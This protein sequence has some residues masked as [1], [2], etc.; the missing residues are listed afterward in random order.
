MDKV[1]FSYISIQKGCLWLPITHFLRLELSQLKSHRRRNNE[2]SFHFSSGQLLNDIQIISR[3]YNL[4]SLW[5]LIFATRIFATLF[6]RICSSRKKDRLLFLRMRNF[7]RK[8]KND[9]FQFKQL[10]GEQ[11]I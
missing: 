8:C 9:C 4:I 7:R 10:N 11:E 1:V 2:D 5:A 6:L 3:K